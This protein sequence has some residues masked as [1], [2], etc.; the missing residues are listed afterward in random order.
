MVS[1]VIVSR[2]RP[3]LKHWISPNQVSFVP[4]RHILDN[5]MITQE[6]LHKCRI[7][8]EKKGY[9]VRKINLSKAY[10]KL[11]WDFIQQVIYE[12]QISPFLSKLIMSYITSSSF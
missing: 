3:F 12:L 11:N 8:K 1:K 4:G 7:S 10:D 5:I 6:I 9:M 2:L